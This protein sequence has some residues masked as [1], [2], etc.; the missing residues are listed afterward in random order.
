MKEDAEKKYFRL[1]L[2]KEVRLKNAYIIKGESLVKD[3]DGNI[4][5]IHCS[6]DVD[7]LSGSGTEASLRKVKG[8]LHWV[9]IKYAVKAEVREY[10]RLFLNEAPDSHEGKDFMEFINPNSL[11]VIDAF[12]EPFL[13]DAK[14]GERFQFQRLGYFNV[15]DDSTQDKIVFNKTV[16]LRDSWIK[17]LSGSINGISTMKENLTIKQQTP[18]RSAIE[19]IKKLGKKY[20]NLS[21][22][23]QK[24][25]KAEIQEL[26]K[27]VSYKDLEPLFNTAVKK[28]G[29][30]IAIMLTLGVLLKEDMERNE[31]INTFIAIALEDKNELLVEEAKAI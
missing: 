19:I 1:T 10:D 24:K 28:A 14:A 2:G 25:A 15:D 7:S 4:I 11:R 26:A 18:E 21:E 31:E 13:N 3:T 22:A 29:T 5:E 23:K 16:G 20:T 8:T 6:Y 12:V 9:S 27:S 17:K 30:R